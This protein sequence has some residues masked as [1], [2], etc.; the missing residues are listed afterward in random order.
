[1]NYKFKNIKLEHLPIIKP[2]WEKLN[3]IHFNDANY[4]KEHYRKF[5]FEKR[6]EKLNKLDDDNIFLEIVETNNGSLIG[7]CISTVINSVG[8]IESVFVE[9]E[10]RK[11]GIGKQL[12]NNSTRWLK[13]NNCS[14][15]I[16][17]VAEGHESIFS[18]YEGFGFY[19]RLT[20]LQLID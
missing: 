10:H 3:D 18:F 17:S 2:L 19:P 6:C 20:Y 15:I 13:N 8:E 1:M 11:S 9:E 5:T 14:R 4:F 12:I 16:V 7:Y